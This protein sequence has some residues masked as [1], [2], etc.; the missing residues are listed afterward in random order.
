MYIA[1]ADF[2]LLTL[3]L[4]IAAMVCE[5]CHHGASCAPQGTAHNISYDFLSISPNCAHVEY[6]D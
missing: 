4:S 1:A 6:S 5:D 2:N 3:A